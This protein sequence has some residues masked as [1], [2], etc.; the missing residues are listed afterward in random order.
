[1]VGDSV[2]EV[3]PSVV[4]VDPVPI[5]STA[6][7]RIEEETSRRKAGEDGEDEGVYL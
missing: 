4:E 2:I 6:G 7:Q 5:T 1:M 3:N